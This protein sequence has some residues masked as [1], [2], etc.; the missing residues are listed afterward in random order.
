[1]DSEDRNRGTRRDRRHGAIVAGARLC[2]RLPSGVRRRADVYTQRR[3]A[4]AEARFLLDFGTLDTVAAPHR[5]KKPTLTEQ[6]ALSSLPSWT[7]CHAK[8]QIAFATS[9]RGSA[10]EFML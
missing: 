6:P 7:I 9:G 1:M 8:P 4:V 3:P 5:T 2:Q 10:V